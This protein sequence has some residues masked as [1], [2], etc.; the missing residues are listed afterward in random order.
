[1]ITKQIVC[2]LSERH[3]LFITVQHWKSYMLKSVELNKIG[4]I[5]INNY[6][7]DIKNI[8]SIE[9]WIVPVTL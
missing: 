9:A 1:M 2:K 4:Q 6:Y 8:M 5:H 7:S 3:I